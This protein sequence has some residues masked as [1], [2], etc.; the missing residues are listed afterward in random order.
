MAFN[1]NKIVGY[2]IVGKSEVKIYPNWKLVIA[3]L[4]KL[5]LVKQY[6]VYLH[7]FV[8]ESEN[9]VFMPNDVVVD[10]FFNEKFIVIDTHDSTVGKIIHCKT[11]K[12]TKTLNYHHVKGLYLVFKTAPLIF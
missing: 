11:L 7:F 3:K 9:N 5:E 2:R 10:S 1:S 12:P 6:Y 8:D 4:L